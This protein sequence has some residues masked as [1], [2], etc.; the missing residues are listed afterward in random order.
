M[1]T[2][3]SY[4][5]AQINPISINANGEI[6]CRTR[7]EVNPMGA[8]DVMAVEYGLA[9]IENNQLTEY[10]TYNLAPPEEGDYDNYQQ[11]RDY[12]DLQF[13]QCKLDKL[14]LKEQ[15]LRQ[16]YHFQDCN[17]TEYRSHDLMSYAEFEQQRSLD[18][19]ET[20]LL[21]LK[22]AHGY[23]DEPDKTEIDIRYDFGHILIL[24][25]ERS[26]MDTT[27]GALFDYKNGMVITTEEGMQ[28]IGFDIEYITGVLF[29]NQ[30]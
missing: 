11:Q 2:G 28:D 23:F 15:A 30:R 7:F 19:S 13:Q 10:T 9:I 14:S 29:L 17:V 1:A 18:L 4:L 22:E 6:L 3:P 24:N 27:V 8:S 21:G 26:D 20:M 25:N 16:Q 5:S 12:Y